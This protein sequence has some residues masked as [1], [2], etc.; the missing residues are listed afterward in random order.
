MYP[1][2]QSERIDI[3]QDAPLNIPDAGYP[4]F[5]SI[6]VNQDGRIIDLRVEIAIMHTYIGDL[7]VDLIAPDGTDVVLHNYT[8][9]SAD[10]LVRNY[11]PADTPA[12][13]SLQNRFIR[14]TWKLRVVDRARFDVGRLNSWRIIAQVTV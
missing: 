6:N 2:R 13:N 9:H 4:V 3:R 11:S 12:L 5:S 10:N 8:G 14:G 1:K 7:R